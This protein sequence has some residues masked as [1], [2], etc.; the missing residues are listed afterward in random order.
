MGSWRLFFV[1]LRI[2]FVLF[3]LRFIRDAFYKWDGFSYHMSFRDFLPHLSLSFILWSVNSVAVAFFFWVVICLS[4][5]I[6]Q[7]YSKFARLYEKILNRLNSLIAPLIW[8]FILF[9]IVAFPLSFSKMIEKRAQDPSD[10]QFT[11]ASD[12][13]NIILLI[14]DALSAEDMQLYGYHRPT[15]PFI[16]KWAESAIVF[17]RAYSSSNWTTPSTM[18]IMT[19]QRPWTHKVWYIAESNPV[20]FYKDNLPMVLKNYGYKVY[21]FVQNNLAHPRT[22]GISSA[23]DIEDDAYTFWTHHSWFVRWYAKFFTTRNI[24]AKWI[25][26]ENPVV[27]ALN[28]RFLRHPIYASVIRSET[29]YER[30]FETISENP[31]QPFF[32]WIHVYPPHDLYLPPKPYMGMFGDEGKFDTLEEQVDS[33]LLHKDYQPQ[34]QR[35]IDILR[36]RYD[37][38]ILYSDYA[39]KNFWS[40]LIKTIDMSNTIVILTSD[41]GESFSHGFLGHNY[42]KLYEPLVHIPL[43]IKAPLLSKSNRIDMPV[44]QIDIAPTILDLADIPVPEWMEGRSLTPLLEAK[45]LKPEPVF[46]MQLIKNH[47][48]GNKPITRGSFAVLEGDHK[49]I[50]YLK[51][52]KV[53][54]FNLRTDPDEARDI[55]EKRPDIV[56]GLLKMVENELSR[57]NSRILSSSTSVQDKD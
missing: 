36:K 2:T 24:V 23:F 31:E 30:F 37:E 1:T 26:S 49:L 15:T 18:S 56:H 38:F 41:H 6:L 47:T 12:R 28:I 39:F 5:R 34:R 25:F 11:G 35:E 57:A 55:S 44:D 7:R 51:E 13:P 42:F 17:N 19:G 45:E 16:S 14:M 4:Y 21:A 53:L 29:V 22:L 40:R 50:Y 8:L 10:I 43:I 20:T 48:I 46:S 32:A 33:N 27:K 9:L 3:S 52:R 54:L